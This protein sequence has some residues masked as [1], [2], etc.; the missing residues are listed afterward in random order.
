MWQPSY[1]QTSFTISILLN[2]STRTGLRFSSKQ[3]SISF[4]MSIL[5]N[6]TFAAD[7]LV[8][9]YF[10]PKNCHKSTFELMEVFSSSISLILSP[11]TCMEILPV[12]STKRKSSFIAFSSP[13][14]FKN[15]GGSFHF[16][17]VTLT[18][19]K[20]FSL[21]NP[22]ETS[23]IH[24]NSVELKT[25]SIFCSS[26]ISDCLCRIS[27]PLIKYLNLTGEQDCCSLLKLSYFLFAKRTII[28]KLVVLVCTLNSCQ[29]FPFPETFHV[30]GF[31]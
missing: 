23:F 28:L 5:S 31:V 26:V 22:F 12:L 9:M 25:T 7:L 14:T 18:K 11:Q 15:F 6:S 29:V 27:D 17:T 20:A 4:S 16:N 24:F 3:S 8:V 30:T 1:L 19:K 2:S 10:F 13:L 21:G